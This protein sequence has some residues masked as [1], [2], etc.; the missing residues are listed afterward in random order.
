MAT[1]KTILIALLVALIGTNTF[2]LYRIIDIG[3]SYSYLEDSEIACHKTLRV[4]VA[5]I[6]VIAHPKSGKSDVVATAESASGIDSFEKDGFVWTSGLGLRFNQ[7]GRVE[8]ASSDTLDSF[9]PQT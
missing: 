3:I 1:S 7:T 4:A 5:A 6:P 8:S 9:L 2:W